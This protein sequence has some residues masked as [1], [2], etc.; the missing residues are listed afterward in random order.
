M[1]MRTILSLVLCA[2]VVTPL[3]AH[4]SPSPWL[5]GRRGTAMAERDALQ[6]IAFV[7]FVPTRSATQVAL[8]PPFRGDDKRVNRGIGYEYINRG[9]LFVLSQW[10]RNGGPVPGFRPLKVAEPGCQDVRSFPRLAGTRGIVWSTTRGTVLTLQPD[11]R[12]DAHTLLAEWHRLVRRGA[13]R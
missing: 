11:G 1:R 7:P 3:A 8:L 2:L 6:G 4:A 12:S 5:V 13:C 10:P 9:R